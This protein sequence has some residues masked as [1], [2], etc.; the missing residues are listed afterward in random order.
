[1]TLQTLGAALS[2]HQ[3][4]HNRDFLLE[5]G[6]RDLE[7][8]DPCRIGML[9]EDWNPLLETLKANLAGHT[10]RVGIHA[11]FDGY[12]IGSY[13]PFAGEFVAKRFLRTLEFVEAVAE[14]LGGSRAPHMVLHS[15]FLFFGHPLVAHSEATGL[16]QQIGFI[17]RTLEPVLKRA[18]E[19]DCTLVI[20]NIRDTNPHALLES[21]KSFNSDHVRMSLDAGHANLMHHCG[22]PRA[23][24]WVRQAGALLGHVHIQDNDG[25]LDHHWHPGQGDINWWAVMK[26]LGKLEHQPRLILELRDHDVQQSAEWFKANGL[27]Q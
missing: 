25:Q 7:I 15:P 4:E 16:R 14:A 20:E 19:L 2:I 24:Q 23:D 18:A 3:L 17:Q 27:A 22:G 5:H 21:V 11:P 12:H 10:A 1:M 13:D 9:E 6:G 8:Q 26:E